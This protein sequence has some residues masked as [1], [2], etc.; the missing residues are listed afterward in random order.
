MNA[1]PARAK[2]AKTALAD[3]ENLI[4]ELVY[5]LREDGVLDGHPEIASLADE[6][7]AVV[8]TMRKARFGLSLYQ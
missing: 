3:G 7:R 8:E 1:T 4:R 5:R 2:A 6:A